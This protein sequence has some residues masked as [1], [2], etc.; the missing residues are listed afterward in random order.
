MAYF[1]GQLLVLTEERCV[2]ILFTLRE[3]SPRTSH[4]VQYGAGIVVRGGM[5]EWLMALACH[6]ERDALYPLI[7]EG[8]KARVQPRMERWPSGRRRTLGKRVTRKGS[9][10][11]IPSFPPGAG[12]Q[13]FGA[14]NN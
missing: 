3:G 2:I 6:A 7:Y 9:W 10:V 11:R 14:Y 5:A 8:Q 12:P 13:G 1:K 4:F